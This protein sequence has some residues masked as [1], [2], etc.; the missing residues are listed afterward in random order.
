[1]AAHLPSVTLVGKARRSMAHA[2]WS[3]SHLL[4]PRHIFLHMKLSPPLLYDLL[5]ED[6]RYYRNSNRC[7]KAL[8][9]PLCLLVCCSYGIM[10]HHVRHAETIRKGRQKE[11]L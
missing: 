5:G 8:G 1:M 4:R 7:T 2:M 10:L 11:Q 6:G 3:T 9:L